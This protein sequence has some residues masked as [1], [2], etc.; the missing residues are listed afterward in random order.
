MEQTTFHIIS[1]WFDGDIPSDSNTRTAVDFTFTNVRFD[2]PVY[3]DVRTGTVFEIPESA[4][5]AQGN[6][7][8]FTSVPCYDSPVL[9]ADLS[10]LHMTEK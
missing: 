5:S 1:M 8:T 9:I 10:D 2:R 4:Y 7:Y 3:V 6:T